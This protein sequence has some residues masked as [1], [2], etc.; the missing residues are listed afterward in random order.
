MLLIN[1]FGASRKYVDTEREQNAP[2]EHI[3]FPQ[4][5]L[6]LQYNNHLYDLFY[7][8]NVH[9]ERKKKLSPL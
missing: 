8:E 3:C 2:G 1:L 9:S 7:A 5:Y 4:T 6:I